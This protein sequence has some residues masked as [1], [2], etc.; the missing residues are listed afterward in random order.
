MRQ[1]WVLQ[2]ATFHLC[3]LPNAAPIL[4]RRN[5]AVDFASG[6]I[7]CLRLCVR[8]IRPTPIQCTNLSSRPVL[9]TS[10]WLTPTGF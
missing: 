7:R 2:Q 1:I 3:L 10:S 5:A 4:F 9:P 8:Q 6:I